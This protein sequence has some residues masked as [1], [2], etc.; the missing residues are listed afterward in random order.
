VFSDYMRPAV[1]M[2]ALMGQPVIYL[3]THDSVYLGE[4]GPTHQPVEQLEALRVIPN[5]RV[6]RPG[7]TQEVGLA[8]WQALA[9]TD[10]PTA[11]ALT[12]QKLPVLPGAAVDA[13]TFARGG[14]VIRPE[15]A[16]KP[17]RLVL[18]ATGSEVALAWSVAEEL[19]KEGIGA[20]VV[21]MPCREL[22]LEQPAE[23]RE[24]VLGGPEVRRMTVEAGAGAGWYRLTRPG[25]RVY[26]LERFGES[27]PGDAVAAHLGFS[28]EQILAAARELLESA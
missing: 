26:S 17:L 1:R 8:W 6:F 25:D 7:T 16:D 19:E 11:L 14:Y 21:S 15:A 2:A 10:G 23:Y 18:V 5:L 13:D 4:D 22:F 27:G 20:R 24:Q 12:R 28:V 3:F 9:R